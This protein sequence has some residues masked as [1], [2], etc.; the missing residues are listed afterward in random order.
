M[1]NCDICTRAVE[2]LSYIVIH[3][4]GG[5]EHRY[6]VC[7]VC[8]NFTHLFLKCAREINNPSHSDT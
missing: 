8:A 1:N 2:A 7:R 3:H 6:L 4:P 5:K